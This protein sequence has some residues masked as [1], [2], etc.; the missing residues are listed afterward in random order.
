MRGNRLLAIFLLISS[1][2]LGQNSGDSLINVGPKKAKLVVEGYI[3]AYYS[4]STNH[5]LDGNR[6]YF[7]SYNRDNEIN[8]DLIRLMKKDGFSHLGDAVGA[9]H[10]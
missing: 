4:Y 3:D 7:V 8:L 6:P 10:R 9:N 5:P 1:E 2:I